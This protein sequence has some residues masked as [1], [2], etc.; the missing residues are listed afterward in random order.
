MPDLADFGDREAKMPKSPSI[1]YIHQ[2]FLGRTMATREGY[3]AAGPTVNLYLRQ[4]SLTVLTISAHPSIQV[5]GQVMGQV[6]GMT[7]A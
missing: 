4:F 6:V 1:T 7:D 2:S 5:M 3:C